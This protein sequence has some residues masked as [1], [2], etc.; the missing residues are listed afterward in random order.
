MKQYSDKYLRAMIIQ[1]VKLG[2]WICPVEGFK[3]LRATLTYA[4]ARVKDNTIHTDPV[5]RELTDQSVKT[6]LALVKYHL[7]TPAPK[8]SKG[9]K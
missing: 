1:L 9:K 8:A 7:D 2:L 6:M 5:L 4:Q 3:E